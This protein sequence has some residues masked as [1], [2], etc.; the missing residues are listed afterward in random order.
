M[1]AVLCHGRQTST[2]STGFGTAT[3]LDNMTVSR[4]TRNPGSEHASFSATNE[5]QEGSR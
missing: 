4:R 1:H 3:E 2:A 5:R